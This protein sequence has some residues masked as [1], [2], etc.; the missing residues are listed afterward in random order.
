MSDTDPTKDLA[1]ENPDKSQ[2]SNPS[3]K[4]SYI[5]TEDWKQFLAEKCAP[6]FTRKP[7]DDN[8]N[9]ISWTGPL[10][11]DK[12][13]AFRG[14]AYDAVMR[15][16]NKDGPEP[17]LSVGEKSIVDQ[18]RA[19]T[20]QV[21]QIDDAYGEQLRGAKTQKERG[22]IPNIYTWPQWKHVEGELKQLVAPLDQETADRIFDALN[23]GFSSQGIN[24]R[25]V[26]VETGEI[27]LGEAH[28]SH[29]AGLDMLLKK[30]PCDPI[31]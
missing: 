5:S 10:W 17:T 25:I 24:T 2:P 16:F 11:T 6:D 29:S 14:A 15:E 19:L 4:P 1:P 20:M 27:W 9:F 30:A 22:L 8:P 21:R 3:D 18:L 13:S 26:Q 12:G 28:S 7:P 23:K 31:S